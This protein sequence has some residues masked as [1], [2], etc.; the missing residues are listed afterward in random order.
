MGFLGTD[1]VQ[2]RLAA[3]DGTARLSRAT[4]IRQRFEQNWRV[5]FVRWVAFDPTRRFTGG[6]YI[7]G[8][9]WA[10][11]K[12]SRDAP[13]EIAVVVR[14][15]KSTTYRRMRSRDIEGE[16][17]FFGFFWRRNHWSLMRNMSILFKKNKK[18]KR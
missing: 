16:C 10:A 9:L 14:V 8:S 2:A 5:Y 12:S 17:L 7:V 6:D 13:S 1:L 3:H 15:L 18:K 11:E 4:K